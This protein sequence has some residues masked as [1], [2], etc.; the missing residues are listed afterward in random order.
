[1]ASAGVRAGRFLDLDL[2]P[3]YD[4]GP[5]VGPGQPGQQDAG[6]HGRVEPR[7]VQPVVMRGEMSQ[8]GLLA[9]A[10]RSPGVSPGADGDCLTFAQLRG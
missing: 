2:G 6:D 3:G 5:A 4:D 1:M 10:E 9:G 7:L 8:A